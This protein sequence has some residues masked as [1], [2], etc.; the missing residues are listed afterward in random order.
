MSVVGVPPT[1]GPDNMSG[2][3]R[4]PARLIHYFSETTHDLENEE[5]LRSREVFLRRFGQQKAL[6]A[7][8]VYIGMVPRTSY[9]TR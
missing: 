6:G 7:H 3:D 1:D 2:R 5:T 9:V 4:F 8:T